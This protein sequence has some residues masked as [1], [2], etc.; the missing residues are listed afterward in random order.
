MK[1]DTMTARSPQK[2]KRKEEEAQM[3]SSTPASATTS[4]SATASPNTAAAG[5]APIIID[6][7]KRKRKTI[8]RLLR[9]EG[10]LVDR[11]EET[12]AQLRTNGVIAAD[13][14][15]VI[16]VVRQRPEPSKFFGIEF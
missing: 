6:F 14:Q 7:G 11:V 16:I 4:T 3:S 15:P 5:P 10:I 9:G 12:I 2:R 13:A 8:Q 1:T